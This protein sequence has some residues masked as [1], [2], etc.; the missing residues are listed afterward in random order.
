MVQFPRL[1]FTDAKA[2]RKFLG[3]V[4]HEY[5]HLW[6]VKRIRPV[7]LGPFDYDKENYTESLWIAEGWTSYYDNVF[8]VRAGLITPD[9][10]LGFRARVQ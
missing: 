1:N 9:E 8:L 4:S 10:Y 3:L 7:A 2:Y 6:N 5:F